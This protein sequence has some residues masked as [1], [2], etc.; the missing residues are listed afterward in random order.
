[1][2]KGITLKALF[3]PKNGKI[4]IIGGYRYMYIS[5]IK[6]DKFRAY[7]AGFELP[8]KKGVT[9]ISGQNGIGKSTIL[10]LLTNSSELK[11]YKTVDGKPFRGEFQDIILFDEISDKAVLEDDKSEKPS[12]TITF[13]ER[14]QLDSYPSQVTYRSTIQK[15]KNTKVTYKETDKIDV[16]QSKNGEPVHLYQKI[17]T[18]KYYKRFR[19]IP[20]KD[21]T[22]HNEA[23]IQWPVLYLGLSRAYP[24]G[25]STKAM[26]NTLPSSVQN[27]ISKEYKYIMGNTSKNEILEFE[28]L[29]LDNHFKN[30]GIVTNEYSGIS[31]SS[32]QND[33]TQILLA[34]KSFEE[35][36][37]DSS[38]SYHGGLL[39]IDEMDVTLHS[40]AQNKLLDFLVKKSK[41]LNLQIIA[42]THSISLLE[43]AADLINLK[44]PVNI[45]YLTTDYSDNNE[46]KNMKN[47]SPDFFRNN[48]ADLYINSST[49]SEPIT[50]ITEDSVARWFI[51][52]L[53]RISK[54]K[55][56]NQIYFLDIDM[57]W[58]RL[59]KLAANGGRQFKDMLFFVDADVRFDEKDYTKFQEITEFSTSG[60]ENE[61]IFF[62]PGNKSIEQMLWEY[63]QSLSA[64]DTFFLMPTMV[65]SN[66]N[67]A[68][69]INHGPHS[70]DYSGDMKEKAKIKLWFKDNRVFMDQLVQRWASDDK[71]KDSVAD[72]INKLRGAYNR[73]IK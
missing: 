37:K 28:N 19:F 55:E 14:P 35:L 45:E 59:T 24:T 41:E 9:I 54:A 44:H 1:M 11:T 23:K 71:N 62:L 60:I 29:T 2:Q 33:L 25:E 10:A 46:V 36:S 40:A 32:G 3:R 16:E 7:K 13:S 43:H 70:E 72:F 38:Y 42:T 67:K 47:P 18:T 58:Q 17:S 63:V 6:I 65:R 73:L 30:A 34:V 4:R 49:I 50:A 26:R 12:T 20:V 56:L 57:D 5:K 53:I 8:L 64:N 22:K 68:T 61:N 69:I 27:E 31:N 15:G 21:A 51:T 66:R 48:L 52:L 39:A